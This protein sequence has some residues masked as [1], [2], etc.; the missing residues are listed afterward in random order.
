LA[1]EANL[2]MK[3]MS[4][5]HSEPFHFLEFR[6]GPKSMVGLTAMVVGLLSDAQRAYE[7]AVLR[8]M[9]QL[10]AKTLVLGERS[11]DREEVDIALESHVPEEVRNVLY[12]PLLQLMAYHR[13][14]AKGLDPDRPH[15]LDAVV[16]LG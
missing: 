9:R 6:H 12:L 15:N 3:E 8:E 13:A 10:G 7:G 2:K 1:C 11:D 4:L 5:T 14:I 16:S